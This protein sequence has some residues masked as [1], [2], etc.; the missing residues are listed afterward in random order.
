MSPGAHEGDSPKVGTLELVAGALLLIGSVF[1]F[2]AG[3]ALH[4]GW[5]ALGGVAGFIVFLAWLYFAV[6]K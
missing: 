1:A 5:C 4:A 6:Q 2:T 3:L